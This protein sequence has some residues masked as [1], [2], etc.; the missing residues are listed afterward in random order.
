MCLR[1]RY[2]QP[3]LRECARSAD[4]QG[5]WGWESENGLRVVV[6]VREYEQESSG[7]TTQGPQA[8]QGNRPAGGKPQQVGIRGK[9]A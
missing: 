3:W 1:M 4:P 2:A 6:A 7:V 9:G 8:H 5:S